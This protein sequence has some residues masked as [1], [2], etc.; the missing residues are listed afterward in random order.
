MFWLT[1]HRL[2]H[3]CFRFQFRIPTPGSEK[4]PGAN[5]PAEIQAQLS[6]QQARVSHTFE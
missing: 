4:G 2:K 3:V 5:A 6:L 1:C